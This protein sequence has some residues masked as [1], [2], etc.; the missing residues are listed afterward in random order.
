MADF[1][2]GD[3]ERFKSKFEL[4]AYVKRT[5]RE[6]IGL[7]IAEPIVPVYADEVIAQEDTTDLSEATGKFP[8]YLIIA[9]FIQWG[10]QELSVQRE[11]HPD[12]SHIFWMLSLDA[13]LG[14]FWT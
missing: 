8:A 11:K 10:C 3:N 7:S 4:M 6:M 13:Y 12:S 9:R 2:K 14:C 5:A 1:I